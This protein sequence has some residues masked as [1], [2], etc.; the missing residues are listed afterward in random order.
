[1][2]EKIIT[3]PEFITITGPKK[4]IDSILKVESK[5]VSIDGLSKN[6][7]KTIPLKKANNIK[8]S[9]DNVKIIGKVE[10]FTEGKLKL[11]FDLINVNDSIKVSTFIKKITITYKVSLK[12]FDKVFEKD[13]KI[14]C[15]YA[16]T[17]KEGLSYLLPEFIVKSSLVSD[18]NMNPTQIEYLI[19]K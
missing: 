10:K 11:D 9:T 4:Y 3:D 8:Y 19:K 13:F 17:Q 7:N 16:K 14:V 2:S 18:L 5:E 6:F 1:L 15:D 12:N